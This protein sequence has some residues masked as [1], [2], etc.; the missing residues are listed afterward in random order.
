MF[1]CLSAVADFVLNMFPQRS[2]ELVIRSNC[3]NILIVGWK[4]YSNNFGGLKNQSFSNNSGKPHPVETKFDVDAQVKGQRRSGNFGCDHTSGGKTWGLDD[5]GRAIFLSGI[6]GPTLSTTGLHHI[7][8]WHVNSC[9]WYTRSYSLNY[10]SSPYL[11]MTCQFMSLQR[12]LKGIFQIFPFRGHLPPK[13]LKIDVS[14]SDQR[15]AQWTPCREILSNLGLFSTT[16]NFRATRHQMFQKFCILAYFSDT[17]CLKRTFWWPAY[18]S[19]VTL[20]NA[21]SYFTL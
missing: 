2:K 14:Y 11:V 1:V 9:P 5:S 12:F 16:Y 8:S 20:Q 13:N 15:T 19:R 21:S 4:L 17:E 7:W 10:R 3:N 6:P 18:S